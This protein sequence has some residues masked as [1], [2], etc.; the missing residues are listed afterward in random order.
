MSVMNPG[1]LAAAV[2][3]AA[4]AFA[5]FSLLAGESAEARDKDP[6]DTENPATSIR[7]GSGTLEFAGDLRPEAS[8]DLAF[9]IAGQL[10]SIKV[11]RGQVVKKG[12]L[13]AAL[14]DGEARAQLAQTEA[15]VAQAKAQLALARDNEARA[16]TLVAQGA[17]P[18]SQAIALKLQADSAYAAFLQAQAAHDLA[19]TTATNHQLK[20]PFDG[21]IV[22]VPDG[23]GQIVAP[24]APLFRLETLERLVLRASVAEAE[25]SHIHVGDAVTIE[26]NDGKRVVGKVKVVLRSLDAS[27]RAP[28]EVSV[29][30]QDG[31]LVAGSYV[32]ASSQAH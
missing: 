32:R 5:L 31:A 1:G 15:A 3:R 24:G 9:K 27:R 7:G 11:E 28:I 21:Q 14:A 25:I 12:Q 17:A 20:A 16:Q 4:P 23:A 30:N 2:R 13:L 6:A 26:S 18:G 10:Q 19:V 22:K 8:A 29:P